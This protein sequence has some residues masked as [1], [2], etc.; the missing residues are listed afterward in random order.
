[1]DQLIQQNTA[2]HP[3][4]TDIE[5][6]SP[7]FPPYKSCFLDVT[8]LKTTSFLVNFE[9]SSHMGGGTVHLLMLIN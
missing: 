3:S 5:T 4:S 2:A 7:Y 6:D 1:M 8:L 9:I